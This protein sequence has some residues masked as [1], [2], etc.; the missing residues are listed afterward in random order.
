MVTGVT[1]KCP[2]PSLNECVNLKR[3]SKSRHSEAKV[4]GE[5][6]AVFRILPLLIEDLALGVSKIDERDRIW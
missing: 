1:A 6:L 5:I 3:T 2:C 4:L